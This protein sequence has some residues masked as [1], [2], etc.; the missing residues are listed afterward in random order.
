LGI[1]SLIS[2]FRFVLGTKKID[3]LTHKNFSQF[4]E[5]ATSV[6]AAIIPQLDSRQ[7]LVNEKTLRR[8]AGGGK[9]NP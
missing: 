7:F 5:C 2:D 9:F 1:V 3:P 8:F 4:I 6:V